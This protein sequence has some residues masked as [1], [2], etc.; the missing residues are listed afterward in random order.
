MDPLSA[1]ALPPAVKSVL[2][3]VWHG[4]TVI[5]AVMAIA[6]I[7]LCRDDSPA[8]RFMCLALCLG[9]AALF[10]AA[11]AQL[12]GGFTQ[13]PQWSIFLVLALLIW[14]GRPS[15]SASAARG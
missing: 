3:V 4:I 6:L 13:L 2:W 7:H 5:L 15:S 11:A 8:L 10:I 9:F 14:L 1:S 12:P